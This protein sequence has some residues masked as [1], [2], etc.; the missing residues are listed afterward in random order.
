MGNQLVF[1]STEGPTLYEQKLKKE[2]DN[3]VVV[4]DTAHFKPSRIFAFDTKTKEVKRLT[5]NDYPVGEFEIS[6]NGKWLATSHIMSPDYGA[7]ANPKPTYYLW[8]LESGTKQEI[9][10]NG[11][12]TPGNFEFTDNSKGF[13]FLSVKSSDP[14][15][16]GAGITLL[17]YFSIEEK[18]AQ[19]V[20]IDWDWGLGSGFDVLGNDVMA[21]LANGTTNILTY[22]EK[23]GNEWIKKSVHAGSMEEH[24][25]IVSV[26]A[27]NNQVVYVYSTASTLPQYHLAKLDVDRRSV[28]LPEGTELIDLNENLDD[29]YIAK[30]EVVNWT[31]SLGDKVT[32]I[33][34]YPKNYEK[35][36]QYPLIV[37]IHGGP[38]GVDRDVWS[39]SWA[40]FPNI[41][42]QKGAF[43]LMPNYHGSANHGLEF[44]E[45]IKGHYYEYEIPDII[46]GIDMLDERGL[47]DRD[48]LGVK[49]WSN[50]A[51][52]TTMLTVKYP[53]MFQVAA[54]G[55]GDVNWTSDYGTCSFG[56]SFDQSYFSGAPWDNTNGKIF[57]EMYVLKSPLFEMEKVRTPTIIFHGSNE[58]A[59]PRDQGWEYYRALQ[60]IDK[61]PVRFLW[62]P[63][64]P[65]SL[66]KITHR[67]RKMEEEIRWFDKYLFGT[68]EK[69]NGTIKEESPIA[70]LLKKD[71]VQIANGLYGL[72]HNDILIPETVSVKEDSLAIG[73]FEVTNAQ[74]A[75]FDKNYK[76]PTLRAN[77]PVTGITIEQAQDYVKWLSE[78][79]NIAF[80]LPNKKEAQKFHEKARKIAASENTLNYWAGYEINID[81]VAQFREKISQLNQTLLKEAGS[82]DAAKIGDAWI[83]DL[84]GNA[85]EIYTG[86][87]SNSHV[88]YGY[89]AVSFVDEY[90]KTPTAPKNYIGFRVIRVLKN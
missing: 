85:A 90:N 23:D 86:S 68:Y 61:A 38:A 81:E 10:K 19:I 72:M 9:L 69:K 49:G 40:Y 47:I 79:T 75:E 26:A 7:D 25:T 59:V 39:D 71:K 12:Q 41:Y 73:R 20:P 48:S 64:Q 66:Q 28:E 58:R 65:H 55:A 52:L 46:A 1:K 27:D 80:R 32:G 29:K 76:Y 14:K 60:Q 30:T 24:V 67:I 17:H 51:I 11:F 62:F 34:Y 78:Q 13:Y 88:I 21:G 89:S 37:S 70:E 57:N 36:R 31:G 53:N 8:N 45:S 3:T 2:K 6:S 77:Y 43:V 33:L 56:V 44:T 5:D 22:F 16:S 4:E 87:E 35:G 15:W 50:G 54:P 42:T 82:F 63:N 74:Y 83:Y 18:K 84:G